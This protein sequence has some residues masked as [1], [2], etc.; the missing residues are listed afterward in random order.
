[1]S[2]AINPFDLLTGSGL[3]VVDVGT[4]GAASPGTV[5]AASLIQDPQA[6]MRYY[7]QQM[8]IPLERFGVRQGQITYAR[9]KTGM[10]PQAVSPG[11]LRGFLKG[12]GQ[13]FPAVG[14][15]IGGIASIPFGPAG[16]AAG[17]TAGAMTGQAAR[18]FIAKGLSGQRVSAGRIAFEGGVDLAASLAGMLIGK[19][20]TRAAVTAAAK[21]FKT[22]MDQG[23]QSASEALQGTLNAVNKTYG[24][25]I[26]ISAAELTNNADLIAVQ[27]TLAGDPRTGETMS[28]F[29][30]ERGSEVGRALSQG[31]EGVAPTFTSREAAGA[32]MSGA[33][34]QSMVDLAMARARAGKPAYDEAFEAGASIDVS[35]TIKSLEQAIS[36]NP[37][38]AGKFR[39]ALKYIADPVTNKEGKV[40]GYKSKDG[41]SLEYVQDNVK[42]LLDDFIGA[43]GRAGRNK[44]AMRL[45]EV[46]GTLLKEMDTQV[47]EYAGAR[48]IWGDLSRPIDDV[49]GGLL[50]MLARATNKDFEFMG[51]RFLANSSPS[52]IKAARDN[53]LKVDGGQDIWNNFVRGA[54]EQS[55]EKASKPRLG[56]LGRPDLRGAMP[57]ARFWSQFG[58]GDGYKRLQSALSPDQMKA[59]DNLLTVMEGASR[60]IYTGSDT[61]AKE[62]AKELV[63]SLGAPGLLQFAAAPWR[64]LGAL[65]D[66][67][68][69]QLSNA[70]VRKL[71]DV[72]TNEG[73][74]DMLLNIAVGK[75]QGAFNERNLI[76]VANALN[77]ASGVG[78]SMTRDSM[79]GPDV[80]AEAG[81]D[82]PSPSPLPQGV[83][84]PFDM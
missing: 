78:M 82:A 41:I 49:E 52:A 15:T 68:S 45:K 26:K 76:L 43:A 10:P 11:P 35:G 73:S 30:A 74:V 60:A 31:L 24:T 27:K 80:P 18:E 34:E 1:M 8:G 59:M 70:N 57:Q 21:Q 14:G 32:E 2:N 50:P 37:R 69:R 6:R 84:N 5:A 19:G 44:E 29:A 25:N 61:A 77:N 81:L 28:R 9:P 51:A 65:S 48:K 22:A 3:P 63:G 54:L 39:Q 83:T 42:E 71:A 40:V 7:S 55:W 4:E 46:Q 17:G 16:I 47:P 72:M 38:L 20:L 53:I 12:T 58:A 56:E 75:G 23:R 36:K 66:A 13:S 67:T 62:S 64:V 79:S 33:A